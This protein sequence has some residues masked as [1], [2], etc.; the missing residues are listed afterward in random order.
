MNYKIPGCCSWV[1]SRW[2]IG[3]WPMKGRD[4]PTAGEAAQSRKD[5]VENELAHV[6]KYGQWRRKLL[7][8]NS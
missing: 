6:Y 5:L 8:C 2:V 7:L 3:A 1:A 4:V